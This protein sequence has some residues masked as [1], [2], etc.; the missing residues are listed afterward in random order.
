MVA[1]KWLGIKKRPVLAGAFFLGLVRDD[2]ELSGVM[3]LCV[4]LQLNVGL[5]SCL[6]AQL[7]HAISTK[8]T[9]NFNYCVKAWCSFSREGLIKAFTGQTRVTCHLSHDIDPSNITQGFSNKYGVAIRPPKTGFKV[10]CHS[11]R[12]SKVFSNIVF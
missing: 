1:E 3:V 12:G 7:P 8:R 5:F 6:F 9:N 2:D 4:P 11:L 10:S